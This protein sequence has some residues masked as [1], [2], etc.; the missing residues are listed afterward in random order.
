MGGSKS[1]LTEVEIRNE[2]NLEIKN[3]NENVMKVFNQTVSNVVTEFVSKTITNLN[4]NTSGLTQ[5][6]AGDL[7]VSGKDSVFKLDQRVDVKSANTAVAKIVQD[8][9]VQQQLASKLQEDVMN[10]I[11]ND[12]DLKGAMEASNMLQQMTKDAG[13][14]EGLVR[15]V[16][17]TV[18]GLMDSLTATKTKEEAK[19]KIINAM[20]YNI[21]NST[22][23]ISDITKKIENNIKNAISNISEQSCNMKTSGSAIISVG[24][25]SVTDGGNASLNQISSVEALNKCVIDTLNSSGIVTDLQTQAFTFSKTDTANTA[26]ADT[27]MK[28]KSEIEQVNIQEATLLKDLGDLVGKI[29]SFGLGGF[30]KYVLIGGIILVVLILVPVIINLVKPKNKS[31]PEIVY[32]DR[33]EEETNERENNNEQEGGFNLNNLNNRL[34]YPWLILISIVFYIFRKNK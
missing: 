33:Q 31:E 22:S 3:K 6:T 20:G 18:Q 19:T 13:G 28:V 11:N 27:T 24:N 5:F 30:G 8:N 1:K 34:I 2:I 4:I 25:I 16:T 21:Q 15:S 14:V 29:L 9:K 32:V 12:S 10:K 17:N 26:K 7:T 23:N